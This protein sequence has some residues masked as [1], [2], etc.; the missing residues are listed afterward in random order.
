MTRAP[1]VKEEITKISGENFRRLAGL[2]ET[3]TGQGDG[4]HLADTLWSTFLG[5]MILK[6]SRVNLGHEAVRTGR[7][8]RA[9]SFD[10]MKRG[11][12]SSSD[13]KNA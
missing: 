3:V 11:L 13:K 5:L 8:A 9:V 10:I 12:L 6:E 4:K 2:L 7:T 1:E